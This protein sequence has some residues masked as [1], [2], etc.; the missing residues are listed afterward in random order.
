MTTI[1]QCFNFY[2]LYSSSILKNNINNIINIENLYQ[3]C[4][5]LAYIDVTNISNEIL[6]LL[7]ECV[8]TPYWF[9][10]IK[11]LCI[12]SSPNIAEKYG[13]IIIF[14]YYLNYIL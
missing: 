14:Q 12:F 1:R 10:L 9:W 4:H 13:K 8:N 6:Q 3:Y 7:P 2:L 11:F 5:I